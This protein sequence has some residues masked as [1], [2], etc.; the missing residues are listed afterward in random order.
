MKYT[1]STYVKEKYIDTVKETYID[2]GG[3]V[4]SVHAKTRP[5]IKD[6]RRDREMTH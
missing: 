2:T 4:D 1:N 3:D 6:L 5:W